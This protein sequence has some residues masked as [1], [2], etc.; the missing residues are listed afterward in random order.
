LFFD[1]AR[2]DLDANDVIISREYRVVPAKS[3]RAHWHWPCLRR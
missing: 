3:R 2:V 1:S